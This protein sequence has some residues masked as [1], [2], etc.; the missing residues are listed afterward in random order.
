MTTTTPTVTGFVSEGKL[1]PTRSIVESIVVLVWGYFFV[2]VLSS[3]HQ[4]NRDKHTHHSAAL[5]N[6][7]LKSNLK[8]LPRPPSRECSKIKIQTDGPYGRT[9]T[10]KSK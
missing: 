5:G 1:K 10:R 4:L 8:A 3:F 6:T 7:K 9:V 2:L